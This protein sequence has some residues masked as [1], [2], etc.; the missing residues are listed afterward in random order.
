M[1]SPCQFLVDSGPS[2][3]VPRWS[4][5]VKDISDLKILT[6]VETNSSL[7]FPPGVL[8][9]FGSDGPRR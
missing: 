7:D 2:D 8:V 6:V 3:V 5:G 9:K 4:P 1:A